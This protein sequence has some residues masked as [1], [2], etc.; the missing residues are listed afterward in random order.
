MSRHLRRCLAG[1]LVLLSFGCGG[2]GPSEPDP[3]P[4]PQ[5]SAKGAVSGSVLNGSNGV[6][7]VAVSLSGAANLSANSSASGGFT[8][9]DLA[10]GSYTVS[11]AVPAGLTL[12][13]GE[14]AS[15]GVTVSANQ[16]SSV[17]FRLAG[18][19]TGGAVQVID[20]QGLSFSPRDVTV[21]RGTR[22][23]WTNNSGMLH[24]VTPDGHSAWQ[25]RDLSNGQTFEVV[26]DQ[27]GT[28]NYYCVPHR[29]DGMTGTIRVQ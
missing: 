12:A 22:I 26:L 3:D 18:G 27:V 1:T 20:I 29:G 2:G 21:A 5:V 11:I 8:F 6:P 25:G 14:T 10:P 19:T 15:R 24:T 13:A 9:P 23:R 4:Q 28:F 7:G 17:T 16:T